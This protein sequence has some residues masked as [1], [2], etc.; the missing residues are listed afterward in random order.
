[1][2]KK[3]TQL[4]LPGFIAVA[5]EQSKVTSIQIHYGFQ[6]LAAWSENLSQALSIPEVTDKVHMTIT[7]APVYGVRVWFSFNELPLGYVTVAYCPYPG[8]IEIECDTVLLELEH[9]R[10]E[11]FSFECFESAVAWIQNLAKKLAA[12][13]QFW[14]SYQIVDAAEARSA[15]LDQ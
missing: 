14:G 4:D 15:R 6:E 7:L 2:K 12:L 8:P 5:D 1:M 10:N 11:K 13:E 3:I 9:S